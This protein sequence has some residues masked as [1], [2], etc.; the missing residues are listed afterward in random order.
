MER[1]AAMDCIDHD[2]HLV[3]KA[4]AN[5]ASQFTY[6]CRKCGKIDYQK[7]GK[8]PWVAKPATV[9]CD[10]L[11]MWDEELQQASVNAA[12]L[13]AESARHEK[14]SA[15]WEA[16]E[17]YLATAAWSARRAKALK[18]DNYLCQGCLECVATQVH[19]E[20]YDRLFSELICDLVSLCHDCHRTC[21]PYKDMKGRE[22][23]GHAIAVH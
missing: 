7:T 10:L 4:A 19:H 8:G 17:D 11:P 9:D 5:C 16:Y 15:W 3:R 21:H 6:Q 13:Q 22:L 1:E 14:D 23:S 2:S 12:R 20:T 18:R